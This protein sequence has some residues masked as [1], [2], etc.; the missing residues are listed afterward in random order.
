MKK[1][2]LIL[3]IAG[4]ILLTGC[5]NNN[6]QVKLLDSITHKEVQGTVIINGDKLQIQDGTVSLKKGT[7]SISKDGYATKNVEI[8]Q[9]DCIV[10]L[11]PISYLKV[12]VVGHNG[13]GIENATA[14]MGDRKE[15]TDKNG[16]CIISPSA[17][18]NQTI[19]ISKKFF[20][21]KKIPIDITQGKNEI[22]T[23][24]LTNTRTVQ[25]YINSLIFPY[26][27]KNFSF[28]ISIGGTTDQQEINYQFMGKVV[29]YEVKE[30]WDKNIHYIF[31]NNEPFIIN[32]AG[33]KVEEQE[34][35]KALI[36]ARD[37]IQRILDFNNEISSLNVL[38]ISDNKIL[39]KE[40]K[41]FENRNIEEIILMQ[42]TNRKIYKIIISI[43]SDD[44][45]N[46]NINVQIDIE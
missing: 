23:Q 38:D 17:K 44:I 24:L 26:D 7:I 1:I 16:N 3:L 43:A 45:E 13:T 42:I 29:N 41:T 10:Y 28:T 15:I 22:S 18:G 40:N 39:I 27:Q 14:Q 9:S 12:N 30:I 19:E 35:I 4:T 5:S 46:M 37:V 8:T 31:E 11:S 2:I 32:P 25:E 6:A 21:S 33:E 36:Y 34:K 20:E